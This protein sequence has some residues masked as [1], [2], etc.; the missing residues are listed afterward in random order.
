[1]LDV[2]QIVRAIYDDHMVK[3][4]NLKDNLANLENPTDHELNLFH[5]QI[6]VLSAVLGDLFKKILN[7]NS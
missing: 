2:K 1:M 4:N 5:E 6:R 3:L 7:N